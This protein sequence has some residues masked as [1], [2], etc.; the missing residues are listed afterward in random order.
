MD[1]SLSAHLHMHGLTDA[2]DWHLCMKTQANFAALGSQP[3]ID[4]ASWGFKLVI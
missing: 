1:K 4:V 3:G 2:F